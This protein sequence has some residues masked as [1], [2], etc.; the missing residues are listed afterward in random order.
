M[1]HIH[2][3]LAFNPLSCKKQ[4][5]TNFAI[6]NFIFA[7]S[8]FHSSH[9]PFRQ[10]QSHKKNAFIRTLICNTIPKMFM[11]VSA[12]TL[13]RSTLQLFHALFAHSNK[14]VRLS[15]LTPPISHQ[16]YKLLEFPGLLRLYGLYAHLPWR[17]SAVAQDGR[18]RVG[19]CSNSSDS[20]NS[21]NSL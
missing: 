20:S 17:G 18:E 4:F 8:A 7:T 2:K 21:S 9:L 16:L 5:T 1:R 13:K 15:H 6:L 12:S 10:T 3:S 11:R 19:W 14:Y